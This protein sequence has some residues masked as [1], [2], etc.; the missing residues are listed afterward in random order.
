[1]S[2]APGF[3]VG[4]YEI[5]SALGAG[6]MGEVYRARDTRLHRDVA[7]KILPDTF[8]TDHDRRARFEREAQVLASLNHPNIGAIF[9]VEDT[10]TVRGLILELVDGV[11]LLE[12][13]PR[14]GLA[15]EEALSIARQ[16]A[17]ALGAAHEH[18]IVHR[19]LKPA[20]IKV[21]P[22]GTVK[23]LD[24]G[25]AKMLDGGG[26]RADPSA[27]NSPTFSS[28]AATEAGVILGTAAYMSPE[29]ATGKQADARSDIWAL[30]LILYEM[31]TGR[32]G[33]EGRTSVEILSNVLKTEPDWSLLPPATPPVLRSLLRRC[34]QKVPSRRLRDVIDARFQIEEALN[35]PVESLPAR[36]T[37]SRAGA[38]WIWVATSA[39]FAMVMALTGWLVGRS[40][41][42]QP[43]VRLEIST[44]PTTDPTSLAIS[45]D[46]RQ[47]ALVSNA[48]GQSRLW[49]RSVR[50]GSLKMLRGTEN[51]RLPFWSPDSR[52][53]GF[54][55]NGELKRIDVDSEAVRSLAAGGMSGG[56][57]NAAGTIIFSGN[58]A[59]GLYRVS[60]DGG[61]RSKL[62]A[63]GPEHTGHRHP[64]FLPD[65]RHFLF[66]ALGAAPGVYVGE[67]DSTA[68][69]HRVFDAQ[70]AIYTESSHLLFIRQGI[71]FAQPF[72]TARLELTGS[73][74]TVA[75]HIVLGTE[76]GAA[77]SAAADGTL[78]YRTGGAGAPRELVWFDRSG[79][80][81][82]RVAGSAALGRTS[83]SL[84]PDERTVV[85]EQFATGSTTS[86]I[87]TIDLSRGVSSRL[88]FDEAFDIYPIWSRD[89][90]QILFS[91][92]RT[93]AWSMFVRGLD[94]RE[95]TP[96]SG[97][98]GGSVSQGDFSPDGRY[99]VFG[100]TTGSG[101]SA[102]TL[103]RQSPGPGLGARV[104]R[105]K[106]SP[107]GHWLAFESTES[108]QVEIYLQRFPDRGV[109]TRISQTGGRQVLWKGDGKEL[110]YLTPNNQLIAVPVELDAGR[111]LARVG[112]PKAL[113]TMQLPADFGGWQYAVSRNGERFLIDTLPEVT[114]PITIALN[115]KPD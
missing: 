95:E 57:W 25:L 60:A 24:F 111:D 54:T 1:V 28:L 84:S 5:L 13:I 40:S 61:A 7:L 90:R 81:V 88:T 79:T 29:Q 85:S 76:S 66:Y 100:T 97:A 12:R 115:W 31:L 59:E 2:L 6:G 65:Q 53:I 47:V 86:D 36:A 33:F 8:S 51:A 92:N 46:G 3:R 83:V 32:R 34:L 112:E 77:L 75:D 107:D 58:P 94:E 63:V 9:G 11:T 45:P 35:T 102:L 37:T 91:S 42:V 20:N 23:V 106:F 49:V 113:F 39:G 30:G 18:G 105:P 70:A 69:P 96:I 72:D 78:V 67:L 114:I 44:P 22:D 93:N 50:T 89:G 68:P 14:G 104:T 101:S 27:S 87:W 16:I 41:A 103:D 4:V 98:P 73:P 10:G 62:T 56:A 74:T 71:L 82:A 38:R 21:R 52:S 109:R 108:G 55:S 19:D 64:Q 48:D 99:I 17:D 15:I 110:Y 26:E 80:P 43:Q